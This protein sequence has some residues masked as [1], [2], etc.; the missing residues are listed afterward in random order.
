MNFKS[1]DSTQDL[2]PG[3]R[4]DY[5]MTTDELIRALQALNVAIDKMGIDESASRDVISASI[6][7][8]A[9]ELSNRASVMT[10]IN[11]T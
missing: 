6:V 2:I 4:I 5:L 7:K 1:G 8:I 9:G 3:D 11:D 10:I